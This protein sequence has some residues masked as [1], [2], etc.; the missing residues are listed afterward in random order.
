VEDSGTALTKRIVL[1][2]GTVVD[3]T[4]SAPRQEDVVID[5]GLI[6]D[7]GEGLARDTDD[8]YDCSGLIVS[9]GFIDIHTHSDLTR[10]AYPDADTRV[11]QGVTTEVIG[12]CGLSPSPVGRNRTE[13]QSTI[14]PIDVIPH[15]EITWTS[16]GE[17]LEVLDNSP[18]ATHLVPLIGHGSLRYYVMGLSGEP[19]N[20]VQRGQIVDLLR[21][22]VDLGF[23][24]MSCGFMYAPGESSDLS[25][26]DALAQVLAEESC[27]MGVHMRAYDSVGLVE[28]VKE[29]LGIAERTGVATEISHLRSIFDD[30]SALDEALTLIATTSA[31]VQAD[32]YPYIAGHTTMLQ[33]FPSPIRATGPSAILELL[34]ADPESGATILREATGFVGDN[35]LIAKAGDSTD[36]V[37]RTLSELARE[38]ASLDP[39]MVAVSLLLAHD[40]NVDIIVTGSRPEDAARVLR[41]PYVMVASDGVSLSLDHR[42][43]LPHPRSIGTFPRAFRELREG[44]M[45]VEDVVHKMTAKPADRL[46]L[47]QRGRIIAGYHADL[48]VFDA[49]QMADEATYV[50]PLIPPRGVEHVLVSGQFVLQHRSPTGLRPG[51]LLKRTTLLTDSK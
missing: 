25:E 1:A 38:H 5:G 20:D 27:L 7:R 9:P 12:N 28:A 31:D 6:V 51:R 16:M 43:N 11:F 36:V 18:G 15:Q 48:V 32:A 29:V 22:A 21:E 30:G 41:Q 39:A 40:G 24:G 23:W 49:D 8:V 13:F 26:I 2:G 14:G 47:A 50:T 19:A 35:I 10:I 42:A 33:M 37:G 3:G 17:Y 34:A 45:S 46:G 44:G 4:R